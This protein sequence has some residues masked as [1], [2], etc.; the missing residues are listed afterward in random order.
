[1]ADATVRRPEGTLGIYKR[2]VVALCHKNLKLFL[3]RPIV[4]LIRV[5]LAPVI[6]ALLLSLFKNIGNALGGYNVS[7]GGLADLRPIKTMDQALQGRS[8][9]KLVFAR[10][11]LG[12]QADSIIDRF[13]AKV[14]SSNIVRIDNP[15]D[16]LGQCRVTLSGSSDCFVSVIFKSVNASMVDYILA[17][18]PSAFEGDVDWKSHRSTMQDM[19]YPVQFALDSAIASFPDNTVINEQSFEE[20]FSSL[21]SS[22]EDYFGSSGQ[23]TPSGEV[24]RFNTNQYYTFV[25]FLLAPFF[26]LIFIEMVFHVCGFLTR[27]R[28]SGVTELLNTQGCRQTPQIVSYF[29]S[30]WLLYTPTW[31]ITGIILGSVLFVST[32]TGYLV[33]FQL[34]AGTATLCMCIFLSTL[35]TKGH[36]SSPVSAIITLGLAMIIFNYLFNEKPDTVQISGLAAVFPPFTYASLISDIA[37]LEGAATLGFKAGRSPDDIKILTNF[38][39][40]QPFLYI[41][42]FL[43]QIPLYLVLAVT[44]HFAIWHVPYIVKPL[45]P[46]TGLAMRINGLDKTFKKSKGKAV[47]GLSME[48]RR[49]QVACLLGPNGGGK[50]TT[51]KCIGGVIKADKGSSIELGCERTE[52]GYCPQHNV[53]WPQLTVREHVQIWLMIKG[54]PASKAAR[55]AAVEEM[56]RECDLIEKIDARAQTLSGGQKRKLQLAIAFIGGSKIVTIDEASSG[57]DPLSRQNIWQI[58]QQG[59]AQRTILLTTHFLDEADV[60]ADHVVIMSKGKLV[61]DGSS[62]ALKAQ[63][64]DGYDIYTDH[65][66]ANKVAH[67][68][69]SAEATQKLDE[70]ARGDIGG[71]N[72][73]EVGFPTLEQ[74]FLKVASGEA[75]GE[76]KE[77]SGSDD[78]AAAAAAALENPASLLDH[79]RPISKFRQIW[80]LFKKRYSVLPHNWLAVIV[81][82]LI[83]IAVAAACM[84]GTN[85]KDIQKAGG[86]HNCASS[87]A[88]FQQES[89]EIRENAASGS[90]QDWYESLYAP[91]TSYPSSYEKILV[92]PRDVFKNGSEGQQILKNAFPGEYFDYSSSS[93]KPAK[94]DVTGRLI[95]ADTLDNYTTSLPIAGSSY[96]KRV[97]VFAPDGQEPRIALGKGYEGN[98]LHGASFG[99]QMLSTVTNMMSKKRSGPAMRPSVRGIRRM[100]STYD[101]LA[102][103]FALFLGMATIAG[104][105]AAIIYPTYERIQKTRS[106]QYSNGVSPVSL[107]GAYLLFELQLILIVAVVMLALLLAG[108]YTKMF[109]GLGYCFGA[110]ILTGIA[111]VLGCFILSLY[112]SAKLAY[113]MAVVIHLILLFLYFIGVVLTATYAPPLSRFDI[114]NQLAAGL[115]LT[116]PAANLVRAFMLASNSYSFLCGKYGEVANPPNPFTFYLFGGVYFNLILQILFLGLLLMA[117]E[118]NVFSRVLL[119]FRKP[120]RSRDSMEF[121]LAHNPASTRKLADG[122]STTAAKEDKYGDRPLLECFGLHKSFNGTEAVH[123]V[124]LSVSSNE[125]MALLGPN[126]AGKSTT[127]NMIRGQLKPDAGDVFVKDKSILSQLV[128]ARAE[129]GVCPQE[130]AVDDLT[131]IS[132]LKFYAEV[133]GVPNPTRNAEAVMAAL[134]IQSFAKKRVSKLSGGT[135]RK[136]SVAI[137][138]L[139]NPPVLLLD[140]PSTGL[141]A[142]SK[143]TLWK[144]LRTLGRDRATLLTTHSMEEVE[145][146]ATSVSI[147]AVRLLASGTT[148]S[149][150][151]EYGGYWHVRAVVSEGASGI[152]RDVRAL[153]GECVEN[154]VTHGGSGQV[155]F[156]LR[157]GGEGLTFARAMK[158]MEGLKSEGKV[159]EY[160]MNG[161]TL[162]EVFLNVC[163]KEKAAHY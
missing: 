73:Y 142:V 81:T 17:Y 101:F 1:M 43:I 52:L 129:T 10:N 122:T 89:Q 37:R 47:N 29:T 96:S 125:T 102:T 159:V 120:T 50:T 145:A 64:G 3:R 126:G 132:T 27:E 13:A 11:G 110:I 160:S 2:Q 90:A 97:G 151:E 44:S 155:R 55:D 117:L 46:G 112:F 140:E 163:G 75:L 108:P 22:V 8:N 116:S 61:V 141:D 98:S 130:D 85:A 118:Y 76:D 83:P 144:T 59:V 67:A 56:V 109:Y 150:R 23:K 123:D 48:V 40:I 137:A 158:A 157:K 63:Y 87:I 36:F 72:K 104:F 14:G 84:Q 5:L 19:I 156:G 147:I 115:G 95:Y 24:G 135:K 54:Q 34:L 105:T 51:L 134:G 30:F 149:L 25:G 82:L 65:S 136:L 146:L 42:F 138:L 4:M 148:T 71:A 161:T 53:I 32:N 103:P 106:L 162:Q 38:V 70:L 31:I 12:S 16:I 93:S 94:T 60:L 68:K 45:A 111:T 153:F 21:Y 119:R 78:E 77:D 107:W 86:L 28:E 79:G 113:F 74:V 131:V 92:G 80:V 7:K 154:F 91:E 99:Y 66:L 18:N 26:F 41:V 33:L 152:E 6:I 57:V 127:I 20:D 39:A 58:I 128:E 69:T 143:R 124:T 62:T 139:G 88:L 133:R 35:F 15:A 100:N 9:N 121:E 49:G 114:Q